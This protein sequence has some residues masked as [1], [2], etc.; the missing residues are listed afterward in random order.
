MIM[1]L[2]PEASLTTGLAVAGV[3]YAIHSNATPT[4]A[5]IQSLPAGNA[6]IDRSEKA[7]TWLSIGVVSG[8]SLIAKDPTIF[9]IGSAATVGMAFLTRHAN[10]QETATGLLNPGPAQGAI[11]ANE[12]ATGP[13]M[14]AT[15]S[16][17]MY[18][19]GGSEFTS[20]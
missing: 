8:I 12:Q 13:Q 20:S 15:K 9:V 17:T 2:K 19:G 5:D 4:T 11:S 7:A 16:F 18:S 6:D 10:W 3:V 14:A 1:A